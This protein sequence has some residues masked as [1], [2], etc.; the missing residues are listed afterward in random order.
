MSLVT[1]CDLAQAATEGSKAKG[2]LVSEEITLSQITIL[3]TSS[4][5]GLAAI[6]TESQQCNA[7]DRS[8][9]V[10]KCSESDGTNQAR[11]RT[12]R[13]ASLGESDTV[14]ASH[15]NITSYINSDTCNGN[16]WKPDA[17]GTT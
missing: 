8:S 2:G 14:E 13:S 7:L 15:A 1:A 12:G 6:E 11:A 17:T 9:T 4:A 16:I 10:R 3:T 5:A